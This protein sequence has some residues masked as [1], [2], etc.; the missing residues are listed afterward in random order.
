MITA[1]FSAAAE[2]LYEAEVSVDVTAATVTEAKKK[3][4]AKAARD[5]LTD[6]VLS[7]S[8][9]DG[10]KEINKLNDNQLQHFIS[11]IMV[12]MEKSSDVRYVADLLV[13]ANEDILK[14]YMT[15]NNIPVVV[16]EERTAL[17]IPLLE[18]SDGSV[19]LWSDEN[20]W[21][22]A[23]LQRKN[24]RKGNLRLQVIE[25]N[26]GNITA[27]DAERVY[28][29]PDEMFRELTE[30]NEAA[31]VYVLKY[32]EKDGKVFVRGFPDGTTDVAEIAAGDEPAT[33]IDKVLPFFKNVKIFA[34]PAESEEEYPS[35]EEEFQ[36][37]YTYQKLGQWMALRKLLQD[38]PL[39]KNVRV[40]SMANGKVHFNF[41]YSGVF[42]KLQTNLGM[43]GYKLRDE[44]GYYAIY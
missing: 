13:T 38:N 23:F 34:T 26:L 18:K 16:G 4:M 40:V 10:A 31:S 33:L 19:D 14:A 3:A 7:I 28:S 25:K 21:R 5:G 27:A 17:V 44:G 39:V 11:G 32:S 42:E 22:Q 41:S 24:L 36:V 9:A 20:S 37:F 43:N 15:E 29:M 30:F 6:I 2:S 1:A 35:T 12:L 8:T